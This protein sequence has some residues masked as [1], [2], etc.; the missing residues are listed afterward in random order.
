M[1]SFITLSDATSYN[2]TCY[3]QVITLHL[4]RATPTQGQMTAALLVNYWYRMG[5]FQYYWGKSG[6]DILTLEMTGFDHL[7]S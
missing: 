5:K 3:F 4:P 7:V 6:F 2:K 1:H